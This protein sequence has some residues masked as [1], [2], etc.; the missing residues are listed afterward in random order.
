MKFGDKIVVV[1]PNGMED[2]NKEFDVDD[3]EPPEVYSEEEFLDRVQTR[4]LHEGDVA[5]F[6]DVRSAK[7]LEKEIILKDIDE[8]TIPDKQG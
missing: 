8:E 5:L 3:D 2:L 7:K 6:C 1:L 4:C